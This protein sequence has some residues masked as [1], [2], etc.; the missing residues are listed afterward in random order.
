MGSGGPDSKRGIERERE[1]MGCG[2]RVVSQVV[3]RRRA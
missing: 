1:R 3:I 2:I